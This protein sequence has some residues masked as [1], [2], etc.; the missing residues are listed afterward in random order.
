MVGTGE[1]VSYGKVG[2]ERECQV[3]RGVVSVKAEVW[4]NAGLDYKKGNVGKAR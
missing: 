4:C 3:W 2:K 1:V